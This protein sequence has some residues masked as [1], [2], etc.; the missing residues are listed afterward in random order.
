V[1]E[2]NRSDD[3]IHAK[4]MLQ[5]LWFKLSKLQRC[6]NSHDLLWFWLNFT[7]SD[8]EKQPLELKTH[9]T[10]TAEQTVSRQ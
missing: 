7:K 10:N 3:E 5:T 9:T 8:K 2:N 6:R 4:L 1:N